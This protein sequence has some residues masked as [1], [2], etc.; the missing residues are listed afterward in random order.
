MWNQSL[1]FNNNNKFMEQP[2]QVLCCPN[3]S[4][5]NIISQFSLNVSISYNVS[6]NLLKSYFLL[7]Y[8]AFTMKLCHRYNINIKAFQRNIV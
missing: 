7:S 1:C 5:A 6:S 8:I 4:L 3:T 2:L